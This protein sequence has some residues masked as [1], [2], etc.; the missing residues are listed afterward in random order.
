[1]ANTEG[2]Q[3]VR[4]PA[5]VVFVTFLGTALVVVWILMFRLMLQ[6]W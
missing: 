5:T 1:M 2:P 3:H 6:R 4:L